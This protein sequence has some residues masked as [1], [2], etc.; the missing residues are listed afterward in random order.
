MDGG[1]YF[2][3]VADNHDGPEFLMIGS[4]IQKRVRPCSGGKRRNDERAL[5]GFKEF[6]EQL[7]GLEGSKKGTGQDDSGGNAPGSHGGAGASDQIATTGRQRSFR[8]GRSVRA[9][10]LSVPVADQVQVH[11]SL[12]GLA[13]GLG[14]DEAGVDGREMVEGI[15]FEPM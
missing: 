9:E 13:E 7:R 8:I 15:G 2:R 12:T 1:I 5:A 11:G 3:I 10:G 4:D 6:L 14:E